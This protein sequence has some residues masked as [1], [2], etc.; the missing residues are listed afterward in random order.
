[1][2]TTVMQ[3]LEIKDLVVSVEGK[4]ILDGVSLTIKAGEIHALMGPN[5]SGK[6]TLSYVIAGHPKYKVESGQ[7]IFNGEDIL[8]LSPD[9]RARKGV[10]LAFQYPQEISGLN[11]SHFLYQMAKARDSE[12]SPMTF[13]VKLNEAVATLGFDKSFLE[14]DLNVGFSGGEKKR[15]ETLQLLLAKPKLAVLDETDSGLDV[16]SLKIVSDAVNSLRGDNFSAL[17][18]THYPRI[19]QYLK[20][21]VVHVFMDGKIVQSGGADLAHN[22]EAQG[23]GGRNE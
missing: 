6:S 3:V 14:R 21:D 10:F 12:L 19:L 20:P 9:E 18:I 23:Y 15:A 17:V 16:D 8:K 1:M 2:Q 11:T 5:G 13:R 7:I 22:I 4:K